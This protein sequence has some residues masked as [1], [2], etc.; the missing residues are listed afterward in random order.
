MGGQACVLYGAAEFSRDTDLVILADVVNLSRLRRALAE[1]QAEVI[2]VPPF[3]LRHLR[4]GHAVHFRCLHPD[5]LRMRVDVMSRLRG[6]GSFATLWR[7]RTTVNLPDGFSF[8]VLS[9]PDLV[10]AK[11][12][13]RDKDWPMLRRL[14]EAH[15]FQYRDE[16]TP[17]QVRFW[18]QELRSPELLIEAARQHRRVC[19]RAVRRRPLLRY[20]IQG[21]SKALE[22]ALQQEEKHERDADRRYWQ[23]LR[24]ELEQLR[25]RRGRST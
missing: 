21:D 4:R 6:V 5:L 8:D 23:P 11:K 16:P 24:S 25:V 7:R 1:L 10:R 18:M 13:Q 2:A 17:A 19:E 15:Y 3:L 22:T 14:V 20:A 12:T 9:L